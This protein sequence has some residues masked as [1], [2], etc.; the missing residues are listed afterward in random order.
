[1]T[2]CHTTQRRFGRA[3]ALVLLAVTGMT[4]MGA[5][6]RLRENICEL[7]RTLE[8]IDGTTAVKI[9]N[10]GDIFR[11]RLTAEVLVGD[12]LRVKF[13]PIKPDLSGPRYLSI[14]GDLSPLCVSVADGRLAL[15]PNGRFDRAPTLELIEPRQV[16]QHADEIHQFYETFPADRDSAEALEIQPGLRCWAVR[17]RPVPWLADGSPPVC[18][19]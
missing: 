12:T 4:L 6:Y 17:R 5:H 16:L 14:V 19:K 11:P 3:L 10:F 2:T 8:Q 1:M 15:P 9:I 18:G 13:G 7:A